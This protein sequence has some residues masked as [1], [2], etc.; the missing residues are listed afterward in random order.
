[1]IPCLAPFARGEKPVHFR[2]RL[3]RS[4][5]SIIV[6]NQ[7]HDFA[8]LI[9]AI[10]AILECRLNKVPISRFR[11]CLSWTA[12]MLGVAFGFSHLPMQCCPRHCWCLTNLYW[13][14]ILAVYLY[15]QPCKYTC[16]GNYIIT[17]LMNDKDYDEVI[18]PSKYKKSHQ[19]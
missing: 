17:K 18:A 8:A 6:V 4:I 13:V 9:S 5:F 11:G 2:R 16:F 1:M 14:D 3:L 12:V 10:L 19:R 7:F 15:Y